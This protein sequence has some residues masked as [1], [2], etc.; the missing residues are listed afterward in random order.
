MFKNFQ[1][2]SNRVCKLNEMKKIL[3]L[4]GGLRHA[5]P[6]TGAK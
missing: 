3:S 4:G 6:T 5:L 1:A 2:V